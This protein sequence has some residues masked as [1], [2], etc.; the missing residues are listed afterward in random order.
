MS[1]RALH[2]FELSLV[3]PCAAMAA[4]GL[5]VDESV[6]VRMMSDLTSALE[7][8]RERLNTAITKKLLEEATKR[9][10]GEEKDPI[11]Q[12]DKLFRQQKVCKACRNGSKKRLTCAAC[13]GDAKRVWL[14]FNPASAAQQ[15]IVLYDLMRLP[16]RTKEG[17]LTSDEDALKGLLAHDRSGVVAD[18]LA[19]GKAETMRSIFARLAPDA[20]GHI[21]T[22]YNIAGTETGRLSS[23]ET[24][25]EE[26]ST[27]LQNLPLRQAARSPLYDVRRCIVPDVGEVFLYADLSQAE[28]RVVAALSGD[29]ELLERWSDGN[30]FDVHRWT[31]AHIFSKAESEITDN[32]RYLGKVARHAL[33]Y[34]M[35]WARFMQEV[36][37]DADITGVSIVAS[38]A[39]RIVSSYHRLHPNLERWW[40]Q[41]AGLVDAQRWLNTGFGR[42]RTFF[43]R[44]ATERYLDETHKE[45]IAFE[46]QST[47]ADLLNRG[48]LRYWNERDRKGWGRLQAQVHDAVLVGVKTARAAI[49]AKVLPRL[50]EEEIEVNKIRLTIPCEVSIGRVSWAALEEAA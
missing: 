40:R 4:R 18:L 8:A 24:W 29:R 33:N 32:E 41:V 20:S 50:L 15:K 1:L 38:E 2:D 30:A 3:E 39:K 26:A 46:P 12:I 35:G 28:A 11:Q 9:L 10:L 16:K 36:N 37:G 27:N 31:A 48:M 21:H 25:L 14:E 22:W 42:R 19:F 45:A 5:R 13:G 43:G 6:R 7:P 34:G 47:V 17:K 44:R 23:S 49:E